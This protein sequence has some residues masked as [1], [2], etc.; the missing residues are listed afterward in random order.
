MLPANRASAICL[1]ACVSVL[2]VAADQETF[3][4]GVDGVVL[5][6]VVRDRSGHMVTDLKKEDFRITDEGRLQVLETF[7]R[8]VSGRVLRIGSAQG[9]SAPAENALQPTDASRV[10]LLVLDSFHVAAQRSLVVR[11]YARDF[12]S[13][14]IHPADLAAVLTVDGTALPATLSADMNQ[15]I[16]AVDAFNGN[17]LRSA[18]VETDEEKRQAGGGMILHSGRD[19]S[20]EERAYRARFLADALSTL[21]NALT[22]VNVARK[23]LLLFS[24]GID[25]NLFD[26]TGSVQRYSNDI[27]RA[28]QHAVN[29]LIRSNVVIYAIDP[30]ALSSAEGDRIETPLYDQP[31][32][33]NNLAHPGIE[34]E[35][36]ASIRSLRNLTEPTGGFATV[37]TNDLAGA[38]TRIAEESRTYYTLSYVLASR[39]R[40]GQFRKVVVRVSR[41]DVQITVRRGYLVPSASEPRHD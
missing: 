8:V 37:S 21:A 40:A 41:P 22:R 38:L 4:T 34:G 26:A 16:P 20:D 32:R 6:V 13:H 31:V 2:P 5:T 39:P 19:P 29:R 17:K 36:E 7:E 10:F 27:T 28:L 14:E 24:E 9:A 15:L 25:Y 18:A 33:T 1:L 3:R 23:V 35:Y 11:K 12:L 30:R